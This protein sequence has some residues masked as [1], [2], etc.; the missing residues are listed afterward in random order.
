VVTALIAL[1]HALIAERRAAEAIPHLR[2][3]LATVEKH[4]QVRY[5][6]FKGEVQ[7][8]LGAALAA[9]GESAEAEQLLLA[10]YDGLRAVASPPPPRLRVAAERLVAFYVAAGK[11]GEAAS[12]RARLPRPR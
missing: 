9:H 8:T 5:P 4:P 11:P 3:A 7:S 10:G 12:W 6:W 1:S 2:E